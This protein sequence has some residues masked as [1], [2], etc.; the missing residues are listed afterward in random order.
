MIPNRYANIFMYYYYIENPFYRKVHFT[1]KIYRL[2]YKILN[3]L[4][5]K[6]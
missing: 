2:F 1:E 6:S 3:W 5:K 4:S